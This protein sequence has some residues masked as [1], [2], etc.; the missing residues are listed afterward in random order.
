MSGLSIVDTRGFRSF[1]LKMKFYSDL[2]IKGLHGLSPF[3]FGRDYLEEETPGET[4]GGSKISS[5]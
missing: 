3:T 2:S 1:I 5:L 4:P